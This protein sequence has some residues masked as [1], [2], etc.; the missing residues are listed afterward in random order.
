MKKYFSLMVLAVLVAAA[1]CTKSRERLDLSSEIRLLSFQLDDSWDA[2][3]DN[4]LG[5]V[6]VTVPKGT[7]VGVM[8]L[9]RIT[10][11]EGVSCT[12]KA[13]DRADFSHPQ[14]MTLFAG[15]TKF[16][17]TIRVVRDTAG[18]LTLPVD[19]WSDG[20]TYPMQ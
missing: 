12:M 17:F 7:S 4:R 1:S 20:S 9:T 13:G 11:S 19:D 5:T 10:C 15:D 18:E 3:I 2:V 14:S 16:N 6:L 8:T